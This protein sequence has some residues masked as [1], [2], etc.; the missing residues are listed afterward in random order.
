MMAP[1][2]QAMTCMMRSSC[3]GLTSYDPMHTI[4]SNNSNES[5]S[6]DSTVPTTL[7]SSGITISATLAELIKLRSSTLAMSE[8]SQ[9]QLSPRMVLQGILS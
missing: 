3:V 2:V 4:S 6:S 9:R 7:F 8:G 5:G 1:I